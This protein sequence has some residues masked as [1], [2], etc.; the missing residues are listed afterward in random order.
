M[1][2]TTDPRLIGLANAIAELNRCLEKQGA[3][4]K[5]TFEQAIGE[6]V[7]QNIESGELEEVNIVLGMV[8]HRVIHGPDWAF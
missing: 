5:G 8:Q 7:S 1:S 3:L 4:P 2:I 6:L